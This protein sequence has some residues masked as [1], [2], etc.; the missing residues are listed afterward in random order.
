MKILDDDD[1]YD[2]NESASSAVSRSTQCWASSG[3]YRWNG[4]Q[5]WNVAGNINSNGHPTNIA[6][7][8]LAGCVANNTTP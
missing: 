8:L 2:E 5:I 6:S 3:C 1:S 4:H 7:I